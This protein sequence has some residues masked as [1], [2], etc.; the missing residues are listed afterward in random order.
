M[1][2]LT[3]HGLLGLP[4]TLSDNDCRSLNAI[5]AALQSYAL[6]NSYAINTNCSTAVKAA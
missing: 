1:P 4:L 2:S 3:E 5:K 6:I